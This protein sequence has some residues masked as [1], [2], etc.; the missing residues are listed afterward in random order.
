[1]E[2]EKIKLDNIKSLNILK[3]IF[4]YLK[5]SAFL[6]IICYNKAIQNK[7]GINIE[8]YQTSTNRI[9]IGGINRLGKEYKLNTD[10]L[11]NI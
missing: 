6:E 2:K 1:M 8:D 10:I 9:K 3:S 7:L 11:I 4:Y 5:R